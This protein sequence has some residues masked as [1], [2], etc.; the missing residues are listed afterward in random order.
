MA[1]KGIELA[2][3]LAA[4]E[5]AMGKLV[6]DRTLDHHGV[7]YQNLTYRSSSVDNLLA[8]LL[9]LQA[10][11]VRAGSARVKIKYHPEDLSRIF[12]WNEARNEYVALPCVEAEYARGLS[13]RVHLE[14]QRQKRGE[15]NSFVTEEE[16]CITKGTFLR[17][18]QRSY[19]NQ[20]LKERKRGARMLA[21]SDV[22]AESDIISIDTVS[23]RLGG[24]RPEKAAVR[25]RAAKAMRKPPAEDI[26]GA[27]EFYDPFADRDR[28][29]A[30]EKSRERLA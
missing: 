28:H 29:A 9:P 6:R 13:E 11:N 21:G 5:H 30:I 8:D 25:S 20:A 27:L 7:T 16:R 22:A 15:N 24:D 10:A 12:V 19:D 17:S 23:N 2:H 1:R 26:E 3:N 14:L 4:V 18:I